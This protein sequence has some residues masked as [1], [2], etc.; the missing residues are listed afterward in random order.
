MLAVD[1]ALSDEVLVPL[2]VAGGVLLLALVAELLHVLRMRRI[3]RL[4]FGPS[5]LPRAWAHAAPFLRAGGAALL[6]WGLT[7]LLLIEPKVHSQGDALDE[8]DYRHLLLILDVSPSM[9]LKDAGPDQIQSRQE[10]ARDVLQSLFSRVSV[11]QYKITVVATYTDAL[12]VVIDTVD[13][14]VVRNILGDLPMQYA[15]NPGKTKL[16]RGL[17]EAFEIARGWEPDSTLLVMVTDGDT[18]P[19]TGMPNM[20]RAIDGVLVVGVGDPVT[21]RFIDGRQSRQDASTLRQLAVRLGGEYHDGNQLHVP[22]DTLRAV[23]GNDER[24]ALGRLTL[25]EYALIAI[26]IGGLLL[27]GLPWLLRRFGTSW[28]PG[29]IPRSGPIAGAGSVARETRPDRVADTAAA[30]R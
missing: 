12:P 24:S 4:A 28:R 11:G 21:G 14:E 27:A 20:P 17:E 18:V 5:Q 7:T 23:A 8:D 29:T 2:L 3:A 30:I 10:R 22:T 16:F 15:F 25:R 9:R 6:A 1:G 19:A 13:A 26:L